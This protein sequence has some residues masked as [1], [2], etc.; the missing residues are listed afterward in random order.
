MGFFFSFQQQNLN[1]YT[2]GW[3]LVTDC[4]LLSSVKRRQWD[5]IFLYDLFYEINEIEMNEKTKEKILLLC[6]DHSIC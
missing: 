4:T 6:Q 3:F 2:F 5:S 1:N